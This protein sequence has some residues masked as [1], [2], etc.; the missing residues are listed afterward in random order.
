M[1]GYDEDSVMNEAATVLDHIQ[2]CLSSRLGDFST[3]PLL[4][5]ANMIIDPDNWPEDLKSYGEEEVNFLLDHFQ[6]VLE[7][8]GCERVKALR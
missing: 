1:S 3:N 4:S 2:E 5:N 8:N 6:D 7:A